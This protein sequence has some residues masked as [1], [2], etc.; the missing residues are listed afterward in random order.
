LLSLSTTKY[1]LSSIDSNGSAI[2]A[3]APKPKATTDAQ[4]ANTSGFGKEA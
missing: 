2:S 3:G 4:A 1:K